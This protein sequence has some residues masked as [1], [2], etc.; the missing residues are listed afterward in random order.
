MPAIPQGRLLRDL[1]YNAQIRDSLHTPMRTFTYTPSDIPTS[2]PVMFLTAEDRAAGVARTA[3]QKLQSLAYIIDAALPETFIATVEEMTSIAPSH[4]VRVNT[5]GKTLDR[6]AHIWDAMVTSVPDAAL[7]I[8][9]GT[10]S[11][12]AGVACANYQRGIPRVLFPT[13]VMGL[14]DASIGGKTGI[15]HA[16]VK[17][18][19]GAVHYPLLTVNY[20]PFLRTLPP[21]EFVSGFSEIVKAAV[22]YDKGFFRLLAAH[23]LRDIERDGA[24]AEDI[25][26]TSALIK[27]RICEEPTGKKIRLL[28]GHAIGHAL[29]TL[30]KPRL[31]HGDCVAIGM[32]FE[33]ALACVLELWK[34]DEWRQQYALLTQLGLSTILPSTVSLGDLAQK[35]LLYKKLVDANHYFFVLPTEIG[36]VHN[37]ETT[38]LTAIPKL[39]LLSLLKQT[40][41]WI[42]A[43]Q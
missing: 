9:G 27:A 31:R 28:Y 14:A 23:P 18:S 15:D 26:F 25:F 6:V 5:E 11:D 7:V 20:L 35:M 41:S 32:N 12:L 40:C 4:V 29:E 2:S 22:L 24:L 43:H 10:A 21:E 36:R 34:P 8:G 1:F 16:G 33:G 30:K 17:N 39:S 3:L 38:C 13:T 19:V 42:D 37:Q